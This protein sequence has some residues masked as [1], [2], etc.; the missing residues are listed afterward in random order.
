MPRWIRRSLKNKLIFL[1]LVSILFPLLSLGFFSY[2]TASNLTEEK[3]KQSGMGVLQQIDSNLEFIISDIENMSLFLIGSKD[4]QLYV[5]SS[6]ADASKQQTRMIEFLSNLVFSKPYISDITIYP[7][8]RAIPVSNTTIFETALP[9]ITD[10]DPNYFAAHPSWWTP[11]YDTRTAAGSKRVVSFVRPIRNLY[12]FKPL[13]K[14][15]ISLDEAALE[16]ILSKSGIEYDR[17]MLLL[18]AEGRVL[19]GTLDELPGTVAEVLPG[20][21]PLAGDSGAINY[22]SGGGKKTLLYLTV[23]GV[24]WKLLEAIPFGEYKSQNRY[25]LGLTAAAV[26]FALLLIVSLVV[27]FIQRLLRPLRM[28]TRFLKN[29]DPEEPIRTYPVESMDEVGQLVRS[30][31]QLG[32]R[33]AALT[34][35]VKH[36]EAVKKE[37]DIA[38]L[39]AQINPHFLYNTLSSIQW[40]ALMNKDKNI[41]EMVGN[42]SD[43]LRFSLNKGAQFCPLEQEVAHA[44]HY[45]NIQAI[46]YPDQFDIVFSIDPAMNG[47]TMLKL[48]LQP[49]IENAFAH[50]VQKKEGRGVIGVHGT[51]QGA[52]MTFAVEDNGAGMEPDKLREVLAQ[53]R[54]PDDR[55][56][57]ARG[58]YGLR[59]VQ[60]RLL[61]HYGADAGLKIESAAGVGTRVAFTIPAMEDWPS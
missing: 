55:D 8:N 11:R 43:F 19:S 52:A 57:V 34:D 32:D 24:G 31:N 13:G 1:L 16:R 26:G 7:D 48:L 25:V 9:D 2:I 38:A 45:A 61:L 47:K 51:L 17:Y 50:G 6:K 22:G 21:P 28:L 59:N 53:L 36:T 56:R 15:V 10:T 12:T 46:R 20:L 40:M 41:A 60:Q 54:S 23:P 18:D 14:L 37:A 4:V 49:L 27:F 39:Q 29:T 58:S 35:Q 30:Y 44:R 5:N 42:L 33:I 3:T